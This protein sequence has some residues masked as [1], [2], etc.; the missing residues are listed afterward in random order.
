MFFTIILGQLYQFN[1]FLEEAIGELETYAAYDPNIIHFLCY[2]LIL[3]LLIN[4][5]TKE[6][7]CCVDG[8]E[9]H[10]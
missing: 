1:L 10:R 2:Y 6:D 5:L 7:I 3:K 8:C 9:K 4:P